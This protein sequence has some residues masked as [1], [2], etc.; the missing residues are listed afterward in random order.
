MKFNSISYERTKKKYDDYQTAKVELFV[1]SGDDPVNA[2]EL[3]QKFVDSA[4]GVKA[5]VIERYV[6]ELKSE[7][8]T[9]KSKV[10]NLEEKLTRAQKR[11]E[12]ARAFLIQ[13]GIS[14]ENFN[15][16]IPF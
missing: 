3:A 1:E 13:H 16:D 15:E 6:G 4:L 2:M 7:E 9:L 10:A 11:W 14:A 8:S 12:K 5:D